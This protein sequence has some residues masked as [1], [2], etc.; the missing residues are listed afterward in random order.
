MLSE[1]LED[2]Q[3]FN[4]DE[5]LDE[6]IKLLW[7]SDYRCRTYSKYYTFKLQ[8]ELLGNNEELI[9]IFEPYQIIKVRHAV[10]YY[11]DKPN[12]I[13]MIRIHIN[14]MY[15][16]L[17]NSEVYMSKEY[18]NYKIKPKK[19][20]FKTIERIKDGEVV[21]ISEIRSQLLDLEKKTEELRLR[22]VEKKIELTIKEY[23]KLIN[24]YIFRIFNNYKSPSEYEQENGW[25]L[26][27][28]HDAWH[29][30]NYIIKYFCKS[31]TGY[32]KNYVKDL[33]P[34]IEIIKN[35][36]QCESIFKPKSNRQ[37]YCSVCSKQVEK[38]RQLM[39]W[40]KNKHKY[41]KL[42]N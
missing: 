34:K 36:N 27:V 29:E 4:E 30:D 6:F 3:E 23:K 40:H 9:K 32:M 24:G 26:D 39:K 18:F 13:D 28:T 5:A 38:K 7:N 17:T 35:C 20:Y 10:S 37:K 15:M 41:K 2:Y 14:N 22:D 8:P 31:L 33:Q 11:K 16:Y 42:P 19:L 21:N 12:S 1:L 25:E